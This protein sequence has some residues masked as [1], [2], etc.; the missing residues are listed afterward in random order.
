MAKEIEME[1]WREGRLGKGCKEFSVGHVEYEMTM[2][3]S[4]MIPKRDVKCAIG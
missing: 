3:H 1:R 2:S 4:K